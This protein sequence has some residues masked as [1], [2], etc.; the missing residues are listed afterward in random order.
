[1]KR[2]AVLAAAVWAG[3]IASCGATPVPDAGTD[4]TAETVDV[5][6]IETTAP[7]EEVDCQNFLAEGEDRSTRR[8]FDESKLS[9]DAQR[10]MEYGWAHPEIYGGIRMVHD[11]TRLEVGIKTDAEEHCLA[12]RELVKRKN[13]FDVVHVDF[14]F[15]DKQA[16][17]AAAA[18][19]GADAV[20]Q[21]W[22]PVRIR[23]PAF[24]ETTAAELDATYG[25]M[26]AISVGG[27]PYPPPSDVTVEE[28]CPP[29]VESENLPQLHVTVIPPA[30]P[31][32]IVS[33][34]E[35]TL[36]IENRGTEPG[37]LFWGQQVSSLF[38]AKDD[39]QPAARYSG[40]IEMWGSVADLKPGDSLEMTAFIGLTPCSLDDGYT[41]LPGT[42]QLR[43]PV[44]FRWND[45]HYVMLLDPVPVTVEEVPST[46]LSPRVPQS[47]TTTTAPSS[48][49]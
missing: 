16:A 8:S 47:I 30:G 17:A 37:Q 12:M 46:S 9:D 5:A 33:G 4:P 49:G 10:L 20:V 26:F 18:A 19:A 36:I 42:Y 27:W 45:E 28:A 35:A 44:Q 6:P 15:A 48:G 11:P 7:P 29:V 13:G 2:R 3:V 1:M 38:A 25:D 32:D 21:G 43:G 22:G 23:L 34:G 31:L 41:L 24:A 14:S 39:R 40:A